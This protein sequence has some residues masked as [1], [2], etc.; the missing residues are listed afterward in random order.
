MITGCEEICGD[1]IS[2]FKSIGYKTDTNAIGGVKL[3]STMEC[4]DGNK[5]NG[6]GCDSSC[7]IE[8]DSSCLL[9]ENNN[10][11]GR[12]TKKTKASLSIDAKV[13]NPL[14][15]ALVFTREVDLDYDKLSRV[16]RL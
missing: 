15:Y 5:A 2:Y 6:D 14:L 10:G 11:I 1:N 16:Y 7:K 3:L 13:N 9:P 8:A 12:C 4:D